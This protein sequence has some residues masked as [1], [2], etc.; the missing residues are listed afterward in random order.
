MDLKFLYI[1]NF[2]NSGYFDRNLGAQL[3]TKLQNSGEILDY[4]LKL[5]VNDVNLVLI[6]EIF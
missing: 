2:R 1:R 6:E 3:W 4:Y 5:L